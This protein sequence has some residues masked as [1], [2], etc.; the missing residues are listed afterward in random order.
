M[1]PVAPA[2]GRRTGSWLVPATSVVVALVVL[3][4]A[5]RPGY[6]LSYD[7]VFVPHLPWSSDLLGVGP[8]PPRAVPSDAVVSLASVWLPGWVV[9]KVILLSGLIAL[10]WGAGRLVEDLPRQRRSV[11]ADVGPRWGAGGAVAA[12]AAVWNPF[13]AERLVLGQWTLLVGLAALPWAVRAAGTLP[14]RPTVLL[15]ATTAAAVAGAQ[16]FVVFV[17]TVVLVLVTTRRPGRGRWVVGFSVGAVTLNAVWWVPAV[18]GAHSVVVD[19]RSFQVFASGADLLVGRWGS[20]LGLGGIWNTA[21]V[22]P[23]RGSVVVAVATAV[24]LAVAATGW[25]RR[26]AD[27]PPWRVGLLTAAALGFVVAGVSG[28]PARSGLADLAAGT[29][30]VGL[31][32]DGQKFVAPLMLVWAVGLGLVATVL[33]SRF[34]QRQRR[35]WLAVLGLVPVALVPALAFGASGRLTAVWYPAGWTQAATAVSSGRGGGAV[36]VLPWGSY[37]RFDWNHGRPVLDPAPRFFGAP[38][39]ADDRLVVD[40]RPLAAETPSG[41]TISDAPDRTSAAA[42]LGASV[43][44]VEGPQRGQLTGGEVTVTTMVPTGPLPGRQRA[45]LVVSVDVAI[46]VGLLAAWSVAAWRGVRARRSRLLP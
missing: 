44:V 10:G 15:A 29:P 16:A 3:G 38:V 22:P 7:L 28:G 31:L 14:G 27:L 4:P 42:A 35:T 26:W 46:L 23:G 20:L 37:R 19:P 6:V 34:G 32:R 13:V 18:I 33:P 24:V 39:Y 30:A 41:Q 25:V 21:V 5:L 17:P 40:G 1:T 8:G 9:E 43:V 11:R 45:R 2:T 36:L 12:V